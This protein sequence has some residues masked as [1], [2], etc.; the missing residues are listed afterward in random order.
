MTPS[1]LHGK[2]LAASPETALK[3]DDLLSKNMLPSTTSS[4]HNKDANIEA[5]TITRNVVQ[6]MAIIDEPAVWPTAVKTKLKPIG[7]PSFWPTEELKQFDEL[8]SGTSEGSANV[9]S[10]H[11]ISLSA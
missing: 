4:P 10:T 6:L 9:T 3:F 7:P 1:I 11:Y 8:T 5:A 2:E